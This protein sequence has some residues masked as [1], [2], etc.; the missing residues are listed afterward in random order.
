MRNCFSE[1]H[2]CVILFLIYGLELEHDLFLW[3]KFEPADLE[4][5]A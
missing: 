1:M 2:S 5:S 3:V 4:P